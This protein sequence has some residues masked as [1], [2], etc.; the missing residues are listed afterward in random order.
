LVKMSVNRDI[1]SVSG[2]Q[3]IDP[4]IGIGIKGCRRIFNKISHRNA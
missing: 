2:F 1:N 4:R 3:G